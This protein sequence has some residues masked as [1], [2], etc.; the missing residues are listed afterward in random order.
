MISHGFVQSLLEET[1]ARVGK[2]GDA[3]W[4]TIICWGFQDSPV[5]FQMK[6]HGNSR[7]GENVITI[8]VLP[9]PSR[10]IVFKSI[11]DQDDE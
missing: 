3:P 5:G 4:I 1:R 2:G 11:G 10:E 7:C 8:L 6:E 9:E